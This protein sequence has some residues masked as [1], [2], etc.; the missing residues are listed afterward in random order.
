MTF[1]KIKNKLLLFLILTFIIILPISVKAYSKKVI[2]GG[3]NIGI[4]V[5]SQGILIVGFYNVNGVSP[6]DQAGLK[7]GDIITMIDDNEVSSIKDFTSLVNDSKTLKINY[8]RGGKFYNT[9]LTIKKDNDG[10]YKTGL[11]VKDS[12]T[13]IGTLSFIDPYTKRFGALGHEINEST[14]GMRFDISDGS[15]F[16]TEITSITKSERGS[17]GEKNASYDNSYIYGEVDKNNS[18]GIFGN[19]TKSYDE[20]KLIDIATS[21]EVKIGDASIYTVISGNDP[22][23]FKIKI[24]NV[25][26][27]TDGK[28]ILFEVVDQELLNVSNGIV[29]GMSGSPIVQNN[30]LIGAVNYVILDNPHKGYGIFIE[31][32]LKES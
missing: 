1:K 7:V 9:L 14:T 23:E 29:Q 5:K 22:E 20:E 3:E 24:L 11:Y 12:I 19:Y 32:M 27:A 31:S 13:G 6:G 26:N 16:K 28:N 8:K 30:K 21:D 15:I 4:S 17:A 18:S 2:L 10:N 25:S